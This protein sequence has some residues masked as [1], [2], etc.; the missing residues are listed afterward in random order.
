MTR[1]ADELRELVREAHGATRDL[2]AAIDTYRGLT[3]QTTIDLH[4]YASTEYT[5]ILTEALSE[6]EAHYSEFLSTTLRQAEHIIE[7]RMRT[8]IRRLIANARETVSRD[9]LRF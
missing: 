8:L 7:Q 1:E 2:R 9:L 3:R 5:R 4:R 6:Q